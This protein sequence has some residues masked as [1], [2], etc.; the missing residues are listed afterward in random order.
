[1]Y[2]ISVLAMFKNESSIIQ[3]WLEHY[4]AE[5]VQHFYLIDNGTTDNTNYILSRY[6][7]YITL[8]K[9][10]KRMETGTQSFL[11]NT[12]YLHKIRKETEWVI[13]CDVDEYIYARNE[14]NQITDVLKTIPRNIEKIWI[15]WKCFGSNGNKTQPINVMKSFT[16]R[17]SAISIKIEHGKVICRSKHLIKIVSGGNMVELTD[18]NAYYLCDGQIFDNVK[19]ADDIILNDQNLHLNHYMLMSEEYYKTI[20]C[21]RGG[22]ETGHTTDK[23]T[24]PAFYKMDSTFNEIDDNELANKKYSV[25]KTPKIS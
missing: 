6:S 4:L 8:I 15:P 22:G 16:K 20:K 5:G 17:Q 9:D 12:I 3:E 21:V 1:M 23:F 2:S 7:Q 19:H 25:K 18:H 10:V 13:I 24:M 11:M 14:Y